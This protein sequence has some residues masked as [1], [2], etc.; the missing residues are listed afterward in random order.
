[1]SNI[2]TKDHYKIA[3]CLNSTETQIVKAHNTSVIA[4]YSNKDL[5][6]ELKNA[7]GQ[8]MFAMGSKN[9]TAEDVLML[10][11]Q[12][13]EY[14]QMR[15][16][17]EKLGDVL[18]AIKLGSYGEFKKDGEVLYLSV[19]NV[20]SWIKSYKLVKAETM[21][22]QF[23]YD[24]KQKAKEEEQKKNKMA[25]YEFYRDLGL[26]VSKATRETC[27][28]GFVYF[29]KLWKLKL[30]RLDKQQVDKYKAEA[31][32]QVNKELREKKVNIFKIGDDNVN[33]M[34]AKRAKDL[35]FFDW[36]EENRDFGI[37]ELIDSKVSEV[38]DL[39]KLKADF[40]G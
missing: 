2:V 34:I 39:E 7:L 36:V 9:L 8:A 24:E 31:K 28:I 27:K 12:L 32:I 23:A 40:Y 18:M 10:V 5:A 20:I 30:I 1:M 11:K 38:V 33:N 15:N 16:S 3:P 14:L 21:K 22:K 17:R 26:N 19:A 29:E 25:N 35:A 4:T 37:K 6:I 13:T